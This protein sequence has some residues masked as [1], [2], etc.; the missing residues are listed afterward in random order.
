MLSRTTLARIL[1]IAVKNAIRILR[2]LV[3][4]EIAFEVTH[5][6]SVGCLACRV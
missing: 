5:A 2:A 6:R 3:A 1:G 4:D